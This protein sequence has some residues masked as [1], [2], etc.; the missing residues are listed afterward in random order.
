MRP[1]E[2]DLWVFGRS[3]CQTERPARAKA[4]TQPAGSWHNGKEASMAGVECTW[5]S[6]GDT[7]SERL[8]ECQAVIMIGFY[9]RAVEKPLEGFA[10]RNDVV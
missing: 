3:V 2:S 6:M 4:L 8:G 7:R 1:E 9:L 10:Q 5:V